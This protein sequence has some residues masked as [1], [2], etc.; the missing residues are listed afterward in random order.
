MPSK[1]QVLWFVS[2][3]Q[4]THV[5]TYSFLFLICPLNF[6]SS[7]TVHVQYVEYC[8]ISEEIAILP[9]LVF[10][11]HRICRPLP[12]R[13]QCSVNSRRLH[14]LHY[15]FNDCIFTM[16]VHRIDHVWSSSQTNSNQTSWIMDILWSYLPHSIQPSATISLWRYKKKCYL[17][18]LSYG[19]Y[20]LL[21]QQDPPR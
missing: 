3:I 13:M 11:E 6:D 14:F 1:H 8:C 17:Y 10:H 16:A 15:L 19:P 12:P 7:P 18:Q 20:T 4:A 9:Y 21:I 5:S 2:T